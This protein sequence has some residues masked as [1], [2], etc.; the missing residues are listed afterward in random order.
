MSQAESPQIK[1]LKQRYK[2]SFAEKVELLN[3]QRDLVADGQPSSQQLVE[4]HQVLHKL[5][6]SS[7]M[8][9][10][11]DINALC[12]QTMDQIEAIGTDDL[13]LEIDKLTLLLEQHG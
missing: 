1:V 11:L 8:Y 12:R 13:V 6:G 2:A 9:G 4:L 3:Q 5:A 7:G 10:Y